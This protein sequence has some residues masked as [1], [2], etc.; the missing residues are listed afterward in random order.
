MTAGLLGSAHCAQGQHP[1]QG[2]VPCWWVGLAGSLARTLARANPP[3]NRDP[4]PC[5]SVGVA[6]S[7]ALARVNPPASRAQDPCWRVGLLSRAHPPI[8]RAQNPCWQVGLLSRACAQG[9]LLNPPTSREP[10]PARGV[11]LVHGGQNPITL[12]YQIN[13]PSIHI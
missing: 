7:L 13:P 1:W 8:S 2:W 6:G 5:W 12:E 11:A 10:T 9:S 3:A 4:V